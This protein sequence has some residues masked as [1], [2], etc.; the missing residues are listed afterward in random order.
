L[1]VGTEAHFEQRLTETD[2]DAFARL[3]GDHNPLHTDLSFAQQAGY[4]DRVVHGALLSAL[5][6]RFV[7]MELPGRQSLLLSMKMDYVAPTFP[8]DT[9]AVTGQVQSIHAEQRVVV[10]RIRIHCD[11]EVRARGSVMVKIQP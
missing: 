3:S 9:V 2:V 7:G 11:E 8:G 4:R 1:T 10:L 6:S 5:V